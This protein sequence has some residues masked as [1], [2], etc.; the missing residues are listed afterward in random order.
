MVNYKLFIQKKYYKERGR[1]NFRFSLFFSI[2]DSDR[3]FFP[4]NYICILPKLPKEF[5]RTHYG[6]FFPDSISGLLLAK[7]L[8]QKAKKEYSDLDIHKEINFRLSKIE[9]HL[10]SIQQKDTIELVH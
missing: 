3:W 6:K 8:L 9:T 1:K 7:Q 10:N 4:L 5:D 2:I